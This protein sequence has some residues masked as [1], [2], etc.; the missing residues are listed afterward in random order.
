MIHPS[1]IH[2]SPDIMTNKTTVHSYEG[3]NDNYQC[4]IYDMYIVEYVYDINITRKNKLAVV[5]FFFFS[6]NPK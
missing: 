4:I 2:R 5:F 1:S 6:L 3:H